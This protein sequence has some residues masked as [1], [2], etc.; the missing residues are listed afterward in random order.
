MRVQS[1]EI[2]L[3]VLGF[4]EAGEE[5]AGNYLGLYQRL[6]VNARNRGFNIL[7]HRYTGPRPEQ[8]AVS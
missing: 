5:V 1:V 2:F 4:K 3:L 8:Q 7:K 6:A